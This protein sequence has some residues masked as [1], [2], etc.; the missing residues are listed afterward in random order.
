V[1]VGRPE[2]GLKIGEEKEEKKNPELPLPATFHS[3]L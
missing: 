2:R 3:F 1:A